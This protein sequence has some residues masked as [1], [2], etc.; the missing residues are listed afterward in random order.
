MK[1][2]TPKMK[3][4]IGTVS[5]GLAL[6]F[7]RCGNRGGLGKMLFGFYKLMMRWLNLS[8]LPVVNADVYNEKTGNVQITPIATNRLG[9]SANIIMAGNNEKTRLIEKPIPDLRLKL[10]ENVC[11]QGNSDVVVDS[12]EGYVISEEA[13]NLEENLE[14]ID[15]LLYR[16]A[17]NLCILRD[18][19]RHP[20]EHI[21]AGIMI[22]GKFC[23]N[24]YHLMYENFNKLVYLKSLDIPSDVPVIIDRKTL[25][26]PS[27]KTIFDILTKG[28]T[29]PVVEIDSNKLYRFELLYCLDHVNK[30]PSHSKDPHKPSIALYSPQAL[31]LLRETLLPSKSTNLYP[32][33]IFISRVGTARRHFNEDEVFGVL[34]KFGFERLA[35]ERY[36]FEEQMDIFNCAEYIV[37]GSGAALTN[38]LYVNSNCTV[39]CFGRSSYNEV[40]EVPIFNTIANINGA[41]FMFFPRK[42]KVL[43][44][45]HVDFEIDSEKFETVIKAIIDK[46]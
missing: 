25:S 14:I 13:Y 24:Y 22:S 17:D 8:V 45:T 42:A 39:F 11:I 44:N 6:F 26:I 21:Q 30:L 16:T 3:G 46:K 7:Y 4:R 43:D 38:L 36:S 35:P 19:L 28:N 1:F 41:R 32:K 27:C 9:V 34:Q 20:M 37:A 31:N 29:R 5:I 33:R 10:F 18:N 40:C 2:L 12:K 23:N 15:G